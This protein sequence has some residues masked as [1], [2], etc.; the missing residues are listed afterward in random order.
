MSLLKFIGDDQKSSYMINNKTMLM[1]NCTMGSFDTLKQLDVFANIE[2]LVIFVT[3]QY[4]N[5]EGSIPELVKYVHENYNISPAIIAD[6]FNHNSPLY[7]YSVIYHGYSPECIVNG[8]G[9]PTPDILIE[10]CQ[11]ST[12]DSCGYLIKF[13]DKIIYYGDSN[14]IYTEAL[15]DISVS[16]LSYIDEIYQSVSLGYSDNY[17]APMKALMTIMSKKL[18]SKTYCINITDDVPISSIF[19]SGFKLPDRVKLPTRSGVVVLFCGSPHGI[20]MSHIMVMKE[21]ATYADQVAVILAPPVEDKMKDMIASMLGEIKVIDRGIELYDDIEY[22]K[23]PARDR[24]VYTQEMWD[25]LAKSYD[26]SCKFKPP[27]K[28][29]FVDFSQRTKNRPYK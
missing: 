11:D 14:S 1:I 26:T 16:S 12:G 19:L 4:I 27:E 5:T 15:N 22:F 3:R 6:G 28:F 20:S 9:N 25:E 17:H 10:V 23:S 18:A 7:K 29:E 24:V 8:T 2:R 21:Y 13:E